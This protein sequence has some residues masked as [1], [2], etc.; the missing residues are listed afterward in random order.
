[1]LLGVLVGRGGVCVCVGGGGTAWRAQVWCAGQYAFAY[2]RPI[3]LVDIQ[4]RGAQ[5]S[6][7]ITVT[8]AAAKWL[9]RIR[10]PARGGAAAGAARARRRRRG[11]LTRSPRRRHARRGRGAAAH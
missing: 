9:N 4:M 7:Q 1:M 6:R 10:K 8:K 2:A 11:A 3:G 5:V